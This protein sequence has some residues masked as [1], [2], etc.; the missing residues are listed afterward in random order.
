VPLGRFEIKGPLHL[1]LFDGNTPQWLTQG[2]EVKG[3]V[4]AGKGRADAYTADDD[5][6]PSDQWRAEWSFA[7]MASNLGLL[8]G[9]GRDLAD[10]TELAELVAG[11]RV[12]R[13]PRPERGQ[14]PVS[15]D[16]TTLAALRVA[17]SLRSCAPSAAPAPRTPSAGSGGTASAAG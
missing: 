15:L 12:P 8:Y 13:R 9:L 6:Q 7:G 1:A 3:G 11:F 10:S 4:Q 17:V 2:Q 5:H 16:G 14:T